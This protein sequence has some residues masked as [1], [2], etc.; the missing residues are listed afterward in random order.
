ML[1]KMPKTQETL[2]KRNTPF[3]WMVLILTF[4]Y[5]VPSL[6]VP[7]IWINVRDIHVQQFNVQGDPI[8]MK[9]DR[10]IHMNYTGGFSVTVRRTDGEF[11]YQTNSNFFRYRVD[12]KLP[13]DLDL[14]WWLGGPDKMKSAIAHGLDTG[15]FFLNTC[16][17]VAIGPME[18][19]IAKRCVESNHFVIEPKE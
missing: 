10:K 14:E 13:E 11:I 18:L 12:A 17:K 5:L 6:L 15:S 3:T 9:V 2:Q 19:V 7:Y 4:F 1:T 16:H 8:L